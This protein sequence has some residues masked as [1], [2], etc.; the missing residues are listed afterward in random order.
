MWVLSCDGTGPEMILV[1]RHEV[2]FGGDGSIAVVV[3]IQ[4]NV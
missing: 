3:C 4:Q 2:L 1:R